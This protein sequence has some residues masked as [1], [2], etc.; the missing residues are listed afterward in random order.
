MIIQCAQCSSKFRLDDSKVSESGIKVRCSKCK[1]IFVVKKDVAPEEPDLDRIL[2]GLQKPGVEPALPEPPPPLP[3]DAVAPT[4][5]AA[6]SPLAGAETVSFQPPADEERG[7]DGFSP[8]THPA[9]LEAEGDDFA[10]F[11]EEER[12]DDSFL[13]APDAT[14]SSVEPA[15]GELAPEEPAFSYEEENV[16]G[17]VSPEV[18]AAATDVGTAGPG[19]GESTDITFEFEDETV[20]D[21]LG[22]APDEKVDESFDL[23]EID[24]GIEDS[25]EGEEPPASAGEFSF[26]DSAGPAASAAPAQP[27]APPEPEPVPPPVVPFGEEELPPLTISS[28]RKGQSILPAAVIAVS[29]LVIVALAGAGFYFFKE[30]PAALDRLG[31]GFVAGWIG[32]ETREE[33]GIGIDKVR[34]AYLKNVEVGEVF[35]IRGD[36]VN[37]YRKPRAAIQVKGALLGKG[38]Q[39]LLQKVAFCGNNLS[40]EQI[41]TLPFAKIDAAMNNQFGDSL[42]NLGVQPARRIPFVVVLRGVPKDAIDYSVEVVGSTVASQ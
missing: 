32:M 4:A 7:T 30:G 23:G 11:G 16:F 1:H 34:G 21:S 6:E 37:N 28:R 25:G 9:G 13:P 12:H 5:E 27:S 24:F 8:D 3:P 26:P 35:V 40:D 39:V 33:G 18:F 42:A 14:P 17:D 15:G 36:A 38:G 2:Q 20:A 22:L 29:V 31:I 10:P 19:E 41:Q